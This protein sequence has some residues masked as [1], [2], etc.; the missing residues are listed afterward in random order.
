MVP[1]T[2]SDASAAQA[3][4]LGKTGRV[5]TEGEF[6]SI[7]AIHRVDPS[8]APEPIA[9]GRYRVKEP[10]TCFFLAEFREIGEQPPN[11][12]KFT[13]SLANLHKK[14]ISP[15][16]KFGFHVT[17]CS[18]NITQATNCWE[19]SWETLYRKQLAHHIKLDE[20]KNGVWPDFRHVCRLVLKKVIPRLLRPLQTEGRNIKPCLVHGDLWDE[21]A[22][23]D[24]HTD[25]P[26]VF[27]AG[28]M[29]AHNEYELGNWRAPRHRLSDKRYVEN[30]KRNFPVSEP[31]KSFLSFC[32]IGITAYVHLCC[33][34]R[35]GREKSPVL[36]ALQY[37]HRRPHTRM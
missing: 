15:T 12:V 7:K 29:Y 9:C 13:A 20:E 33:R 23:T 16:G 32:Y 1:K 36:A 28:S 25:E 37:W 4:S 6:E 27:N 8:F 18:G 26:F 24:M 21:N 5:M 31:S 10:E 30:Y 19:D 35:L 2:I 14:S 11:P 34:G 22:A 17:T 3:I